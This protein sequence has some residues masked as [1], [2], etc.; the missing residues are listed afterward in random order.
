MTATRLRTMLLPAATVLVGCAAAGVVL[1]ADPTS[2]A[3]FPLPPCPVK[4]LTGLDCPGCGAT[5]MFYS[6]LHGDVLSA[7]HYN[8]ALIA[9]IPFFLWTWG[10]WVLGRW[11][12]RRIPTWE[13]WRWS[14]MAGLVLIAV[15]AVIRN[16]PFPPFTALYV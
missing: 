8:A 14:P 11:Q 16:L 4:W 7:L 13:Q 15:W 10:A 1:A 12:G 2:D 6:L 3:G 9:F 5:R